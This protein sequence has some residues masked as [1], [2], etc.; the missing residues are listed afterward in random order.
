MPYRT[1]GRVEPEAKDPLWR[2]PYIWTPLGVAVFV[3]TL[4]LALLAPLCPV[5]SLVPFF[6]PLYAAITLALLFAAVYSSQPVSGALTV[7][8]LH[9]VFFAL[10]TSFEAYH[11]FVRYETAYKKDLECR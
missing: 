6:H 3:L 10:A 4:P 7:A 5:P 2:K 11:P 8:G 9:A 1:P